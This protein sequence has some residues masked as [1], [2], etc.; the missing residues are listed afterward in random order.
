MEEE[1]AIGKIRSA[2][3]NNFFFLF[4]FFVAKIDFRGGTWSIHLVGTKGS[5]IDFSPS[6]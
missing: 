5:A 3:Y 4:L 6:K 2:K 1:D